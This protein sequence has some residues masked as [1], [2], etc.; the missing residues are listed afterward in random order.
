MA[1]E[2]IEVGIEACSFYEQMVINS[3]EPASETPPAAVDSQKLA[4]EQA[5]PAGINQAV[6]VTEVKLPTGA[7]VMPLPP[8]SIAKTVAAAN[9]GLPS[10]QP[11][12][13]EPLSGSLPPLAGING[14]PVQFK[15]SLKSFNR[16]YR[17]GKLLGK[18]F[19]YISFPFTYF[20]IR[21]TYDT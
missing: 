2:K 18:K 14:G 5:L 19:K 3:T 7:V 12:V 11:F 15:P 13:A 1:S 8:P 9:S 6:V 4:F 20:P 21:F 16:S 17:V 10:P